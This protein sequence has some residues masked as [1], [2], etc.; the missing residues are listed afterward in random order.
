MH[1][2]KI[3]IVVDYDSEDNEGYQYMIFDGSDEYPVDGGFCTSTLENALEM[4]YE[5]AKKVLARN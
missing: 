5:D 3:E 1:E 4:A 2:L